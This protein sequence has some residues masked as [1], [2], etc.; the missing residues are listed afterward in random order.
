MLK[1]LSF[2]L[3][4]T[5]V[6]AAAQTATFVQGQPAQAA[7]PS[8]LSMVLTAGAAPCTVTGDTFP[9]QN[10]IISNC[11]IGGATIPGFTIPNTVQL[12]WALT[13]QVNTGTNAQTFILNITAN[14]PFKIQATVN[15][16]TPVSGTF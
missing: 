9:A 2:F 12:P 11:T 5:S 7:K 16:Q 3:L 13:I 1:K 4:I 14:N 10:I 8:Q 6:L 15:G